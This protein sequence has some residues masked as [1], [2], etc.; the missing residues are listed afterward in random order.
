[1]GL[2]VDR[3]VSKI[4][5]EILALLID[6]EDPRFAWHVRNERVKTHPSSHL[7]FSL[8]CRDPLEAA[9]AGLPSLVILCKL[10]GLDTDCVLH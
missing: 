6:N 2:R 9:V 3:K 8:S 7:R 10:L 5:A 4:W 1:M